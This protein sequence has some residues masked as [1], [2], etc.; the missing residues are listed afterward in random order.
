MNKIFKSLDAILESV[1][2]L[3]SLWI[4]A[5]IIGL[6]SFEQSLEISSD[7]YNEVRV[8]RDNNPCVQQL[9][10]TA[11]DDGYISGFEYEDI[12]LAVLNHQKAAALTQAKQQLQ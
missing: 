5:L 2:N 8:L 1:F 4:V 6:I 12:R 3:I 11:M 9:V 10:K 7:R